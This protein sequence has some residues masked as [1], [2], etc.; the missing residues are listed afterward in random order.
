MFQSQRSDPGHQLFTHFP[1]V[2]L[3][4]TLHLAAAQG[5]AAPAHKDPVL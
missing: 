2:L 1:S 3:N 5:H 4:V